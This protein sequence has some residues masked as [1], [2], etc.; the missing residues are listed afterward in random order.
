MECTNGSRKRGGAR[1]YIN[2]NEIG[3]LCALFGLEGVL[4]RLLDLLPEAIK[5]I[6]TRKFSKDDTLEVF[7][8]MLK[9]LAKKTVGL[10]YDEL[11]NGI[12]IA[13]FCELEPPPLPEPV[14]FTDIF[15][16]IAELVPILSY[17]FTANEVLTG[18]STKILDKIVGFWLREQ[19]F[20][21]CECIPDEP[22]ENPPPPPSDSPIDIP[23]CGE[24][25]PPRPCPNP[26]A[27]CNGFDSLNRPIRAKQFCF[28]Y[29]QKTEVS[30]SNGS[31]VQ[32]FVE[33]NNTNESNYIAFPNGSVLLHPI[34]SS[35]QFGAEPLYFDYGDGWVLGSANIKSSGYIPPCPPCI[36]EA[37]KGTKDFC[38]LF[39]DDPICLPDEG[40]GDC[41]IE[42]VLVEEFIDC[43]LPTRTVRLELNV[44]G[45]DV[46]VTVA[47][48]SECE[49]DRITK[50]MS[51][52]ECINGV[53]IFGCTDPLA[54]N[55][56]PDATI[57]NGTCVFEQVTYG[58]TDPNALN[59]NP[60]AVTDD[61]S[62]IYPVYGCTD[63]DALNYNPDATD[64]D[65]SCEYEDTN[66]YGCTDPLATSYN[67]DATATDGSC[68]FPPELLGCRDSRA[69]NYN[70]DAVIDDGSC[71]YPPEF[72][73]CTN[74]VALNFNPDAL[75]DDGSCIY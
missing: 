6:A 23:D 49:S 41:G 14:S 36:E 29:R 53:D 4:C 70:P 24:N 63:P 55:Y 65:G 47:E 46:P 64:D 66:I 62:C 34:I 17:F 11:V 15:I 58:C 67:P 31:W 33:A 71:I 59:Y 8:E 12:E 3:V 74:P 50:Q 38:A 13:R 60:D 40:E 39:P 44:N 1:D 72:Q 68:I 42:F 45:R 43:G 57:E 16:F 32:Y 48:F 19:W 27:I 35:S 21:N 25:C 20:K 61:G 2:T 10:I 56:N 52:Y 54:L 22:V 75:Q 51:L 5:K 28:G 37:T 9:Q 26:V 18:D 30:S 7:E 69:T 73:G